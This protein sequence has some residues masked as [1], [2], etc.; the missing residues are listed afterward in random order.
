MEIEYK[1]FYKLG[2]DWQWK[3]FYF[4]AENDQDARDYAE[5]YAKDFNLY[6]F[7]VERITKERIL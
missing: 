3:Y 4:N 1:L 5:K 7:G 2:I 6:K